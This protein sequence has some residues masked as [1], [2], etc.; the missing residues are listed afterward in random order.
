MVS[1]VAMLGLRPRGDAVL[2]VSYSTCQ[3]AL[4][5]VVFLSRLDLPTLTPSKIKMWHLPSEIC[6]REPLK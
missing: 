3:F 2:F 4:L 5:I 1:A 6:K